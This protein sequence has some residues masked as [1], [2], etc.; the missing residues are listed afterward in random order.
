[1]SVIRQPGVLGRATRRRVVGTTAALSAAALETVA[2]GLWFWLLVGSKTTSTAL[3]GLGILFCGAL[4]RTSLF[5]ATVSQL[6]DFL[7]PRRLGAAVAWTASWVLWLLV[8]DTVGGITG[9]VAATAGLVGLLVVQFAFERRAFRVRG[10]RGLV[11]PATLAPAVALAV[12]AAALLASG[13]VTEWT[14]VSPPISLG[15][16]TFVIRIEAIHVGLVL[17]A[18]AAFLAHKQRFQ[19]LLSYDGERF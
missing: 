16:T 3:A 11:S 4:L 12:G 10:G 2:V 18:F 19:R 5:E 8:A 14:L 9:I 7:H 1:M 6:G 13:R 17:F 15:V